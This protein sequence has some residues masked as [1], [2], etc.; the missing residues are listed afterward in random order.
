MPHYCI[1][2]KH[3]A[4]HSNLFVSLEREAQP[5]YKICSACSLAAVRQGYAVVYR[6]AA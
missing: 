1:F 6:P 5:R 3:D 2:C 4:K